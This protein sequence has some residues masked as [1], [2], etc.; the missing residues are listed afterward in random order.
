MSGRP[1]EPITAPGAQLP[2]RPDRLPGMQTARATRRARL[3]A[4]IG[5]AL[6]LVGLLVVLG[7]PPVRA[8]SGALVGYAEIRDEATRIVLGRVAGREVGAGGEMTSLL[9]HVDAVIRGSA[10]AELV[11]DPPTY[12]GCEGRIDEPVGAQLVIATGPQYFDA[13]VTGDLHPYW[14]VRD[15][16]TVDP[17]GVWQEDPGIRTLDELVADLGGRLVPVEGAAA[18]EGSQAGGLQ[19]LPI[20]LGGAAILGLAIVVI[21]VT[22]RISSRRDA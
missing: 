12:M 17:I 13:A 16:G 19:P 2:G 8:C 11:L 22:S 14:L 9:I 1:I 3:Q 15:D 10:P 7:A 18:G 20:A 21:A 4:A 5:G 6:V